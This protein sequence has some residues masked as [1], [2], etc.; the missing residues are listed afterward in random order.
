MLNMLGVSSVKLPVIMEG[1]CSS[2]CFGAEVE[3]E[4]CLVGWGGSAAVIG[5]REIVG[6]SSGG[7]FLDFKNLLGAFIFFMALFTA[8]LN[9]YSTSAYSSSALS[10]SN[11]VNY[12]INFMCRRRIW[13]SSTESIILIPKQLNHK[14]NSKQFLRKY[15]N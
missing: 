10:E 11:V 14:F 13:H 7:G 9:A 15:Y 5:G 2:V 12:D 8:S 6:V 3:G 1:S 4:D